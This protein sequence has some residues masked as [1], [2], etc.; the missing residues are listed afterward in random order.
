M[1]AKLR[2]Q[3][4]LGATALA[5]TLVKP[6]IALC[7]DAIPDEAPG[8]TVS[9]QTVSG[10]DAAVDQLRQQLNSLQFMLER[11]NRVIEELQNKLNDRERSVNDP[12][13]TPVNAGPLSADAEVVTKSELDRHID[14]A[15]ARFEEEDK[16]RLLPMGVQMGYLMNNGFYI[17]SVPD[18]KFS[19]WEG[20]EKIPFELRIRG[21]LQLDYYNFQDSD[22]T[23]HQQ[24]LK[25]P[26]AFGGV[27]NDP[28]FSALEVKRMRLIFEGTAFD[29]DLKYKIQLNADTRGL[30]GFFNNNHIVGGSPGG[31]GAAAVEGGGV[32]TDHAMR[33]FE[34][35]VS[36]DCHGQEQCYECDDPCNPHVPNY[37]PTYTFIA[38]KIKP[39]C[40][41]EEYLGSANEQFVEFSAADW[42]FSPDDDNLFMGAGVQGKMYDD[43][44]FWLAYVTNGSESNFAANQIDNW[45]GFNFGAWYDFGGTWDEDKKKWKLFGDS[46]S[47]IDTSQNWVVRVG[48]GANIAPMNHRALYGDEEQSRFRTSDGGAR[49]IDILNGAGNGNNA[50]DRFNAYSVNAFV[51]AKHCGFSIS[52]EWWYRL[53]NDFDTVPAGNGVIMYRD[54]STGAPVAHRFN[55][56]SLTDFGMQLQ[57]G[58]FICPEK[59]ELVGRWSSIW[60]NSGNV[61]NDFNSNERF[62]EYTLGLNYFMHR[63]QLKWQ[64]DVGVYEGGNPASAS[65]AGFQTN[66]DGMLFRTQLQLAF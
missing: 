59:V 19:N 66:R 58:Y 31:G 6:T 23:N 47:D 37:R 33:L 64:T 10:P 51:A 26:P 25:F 56:D 42:F 29:P 44:L 36:Y 3:K 39:W 49:I 60:G 1:K 62:D 35:W 48:A 45:P 65:A 27:Q 38:G 5:L 30:G 20:K 16:K 9:V 4:L 61:N 53:L 21:R 32:T 17:R 18:P 22:R 28:D 11:Q 12:D 8:T 57:G 15:L 43:R 7:Q 13:V 55:E 14:A 54:F 46:M 50:V 41:I 40:G 52:N 63:H 24:N 2:H 34:A